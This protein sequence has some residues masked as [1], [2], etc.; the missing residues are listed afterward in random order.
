M[1]TYFKIAC[2]FY[3]FNGPY[4]NMVFCLLV[5]MLCYNLKH[6]GFQKTLMTS[7]LGLLVVSGFNPFRANHDY[8]RF[9]YV[10]LTD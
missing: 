8:S 7:M 2:I 10:L 6:K 1:Q 5:Y 9:K 4:Q 3:K